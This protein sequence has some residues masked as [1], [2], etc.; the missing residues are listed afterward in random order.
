[1][2]NLRYQNKLIFLILGFFFSIN[3]CSVAYSATYFVDYETGNDLFSGLTSGSPWKHCPGD[4]R[5]INNADITL[6]AGDIVVFKGGVTYSFTSGATDDYIMA[7]ASGSSGNVITYRS[8]HIHSPQWGTSRAVIDGTNADIDGTPNGVLDLA[9][10][11]Y[12]TVEGLEVTKMPTNGGYYGIISWYNSSGGNIIIDNCYIHYSNSDGIYIRG[13]WNSGTNPSNFTIKNSTIENTFQHNIQIRAGIDDV[14]IQNN[15]F[16]LAGN[17]PYGHGSAVGD[18]IAL[19]YGGTDTQDNINIIGND[20]NDTCAVKSKGH[21]LMQQEASNIT[22][23]DNYV[24]GGVASGSFII[25]GPITN[26]IIRNNV[27]HM[28]VTTYQGVLRFLS[29]QESANIDNIKIHNNTF[30]CSSTFTSADHGIIH[31]NSF[32]DPDVQYTN[33]D[34]RNNIIDTDTVNHKTDFLIFINNTDGDDPVVDTSTF[35]CDYNSY[36]NINSSGDF[37]YIEDE[38]AMT[39]AEW[40]TWLSNEGVSGADAHSTFGQVTFLNEAGDDFHLSSG[41]SY[42]LNQGTDLSGQ[43]FSDDKDGILRP[44]KLVWDIGAYERGIGP[45]APKNFKFN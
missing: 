17:D 6:S 10:Y 9:T 7:N 14:T 36:Q 29:D 35:T 12:I 18:C 1:M 30:V 39:F 27:F 38:G 31:F 16:D 21:I 33:V 25:N 5:A 13:L 4:P 20:L 34:I 45:D 23:E 15:N 8:G 11:S 42:A 19:T 22:V 40:K 2:I 37:F 32:A 24:H 41:D 26:L 28:E 3:I 44:Q 43:G